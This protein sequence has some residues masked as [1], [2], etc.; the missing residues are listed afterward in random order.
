MLDQ[1]GKAVTVTMG[2]YG[3]GVSRAIAVVAEQTA[4][5]RGLCWPRELA[6]A[7]V[8]VV[9]AGKTEEIKAGAAQLADAIAA[10]GLEV[11]LDDRKD[12]SPGVKFNDSELLGVPT[13]V[14]VGKR[15]ADGL[16]EIRDRKTG[17]KRRFRSKALRS[18]SPPSSALGDRAGRVGRSAP[19]R[20]SRSAGPIPPNPHA[21]GT[22]V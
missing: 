20:I 11:L 7:D 1:N 17:E 8:H 5:D 6:P 14:V 4:D 2:S 15:L 21:H 3:V 13:I 22:S 19:C 16:V 18:V 9:A 12:V 10:T